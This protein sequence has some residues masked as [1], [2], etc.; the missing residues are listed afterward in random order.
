MVKFYFNTRI[1]FILGILFISQASAQSIHISLRVNEEEQDSVFRDEPLLFDVQV[2]NKQAQA[3]ARWNM[4]GERRLMEM[5]ESL[6]QGRLSREEYEREKSVIEKARRKVEITTLG[7]SATSWTSAIHWK[8]TNTAD[9]KELKWPIMLMMNPATTGTAVLDANGFYMASFG[10]SP[11]AMQQLPV[12]TY[13]VEVSIENVYSNA[14]LVIIRSRLMT[15]TIAGT[16]PMLLR[17]GRFYW[18]AGDGEKTIRF[19][20]LMLSQD[21]SSLDGLSLKG[22]GQVLQRNYLPALE[23]FNNALKLY[24]KK[25]G[26]EAEPP[27]YLLSTIAFLKHSLGEPT[28]SR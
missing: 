23:T 6:K 5:D 24:Y 18:H 13:T 17:I 19:A 20:E 11:E 3:N 25:F 2:S 26:N 16:E 14:V 9:R 22:D 4:A 12:G 27:E 28:R 7:S 15:E 8:V 1:L 10:L 21:P